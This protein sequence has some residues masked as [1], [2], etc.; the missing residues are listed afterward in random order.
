MYECMENKNYKNDDAMNREN[1]G[2]LLYA[3]MQSEHILADDS[4]VVA[5]T[6]G[7]GSGK[8]H[9]LGM[10]ESKIRTLED[11]KPFVVHINAWESD[12]SGEP[13]LAVVSA[14]AKQ[15]EER[16]DFDDKSLESLKS[17]AGM[18]VRGTTTL[19]KDAA[20]NL[21]EKNTGIELNNAVEK[22]TEKQSDKMLNRKAMS[23]FEDFEARQQ[24]IKD[25]RTALKGLVREL[26]AQDGLKLIL[27]V[28]ELDRCRPTYA[29]DM[30]EALKHLFNV[31]GLAVLLAVDWEQLSCTARA[32]FGHKLD[33]TEY[34]RKFVTRRV[35]LP[36]P[37]TQELKKLIARFWGKFIASKELEKL[38]RKTLAPP[39]FRAVDMTAAILIGLGVKKARQIED[40]SRV[41]SHFFLLGEGGFENEASV[42]AKLGCIILL[43][44][45]HVVNSDNLL[46]IANG[47][48][49]AEEILDLVFKLTRRED[50][51]I[52]LNLDLLES[53]MISS[54]ISRTNFEELEAAFLIRTPPD[55]VELRKRNRTMPSFSAGYH[56]GW[57][58][59]WARLIDTLKN[60]S[61][62]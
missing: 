17:A 14:I 2:D 46:R 13:V 54:F 29:I 59:E 38:S 44:A 19:L 5:L 12:H 48:M 43:S 55:M 34:L 10:W 33:T 56:H 24:A 4:F 42:D 21:L 40:F 32:L 7:F 15:L 47:S 60:F 23:L 25:M 20:I 3:F 8:S 50:R 26:D 6:G 62:A 22:L 51:E 35:S 16:K 39:A 11:P 58:Y 28:D 45:L 27:V 1:F 52:E 18:V 53:G 30:L 41:L 49:T 57:I 9:F 31:K 37:G 36:E 61:E